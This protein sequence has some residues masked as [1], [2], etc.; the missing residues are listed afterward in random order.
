MIVALSFYGMSTFEGPLMSL[1]SVNAL[2]HYTDWTIGHVHSGALG[3]VAMITFG[4]LYHLLPRLWE[5]KMYS[6]RL[7]YMHFWLATIGIVLYISSMWVAGIGQGLLLR[8]F[9][10]YG[11]LAYTFIE[12]VAFLHQPYV[13]RALGGLFF[14][15]GMVLMAINTFM[16]IRKARREQSELEAKLAAKLANA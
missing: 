9:D 7:I 11:N 10:D 14:V 16:T 1:K 6:A 8:A 4:S 3:W 5:T 13:F 15:S 2:S 12:S